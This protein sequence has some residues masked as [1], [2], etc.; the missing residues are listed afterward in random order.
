MNEIKECRCVECE[1]VKSNL[2]FTT[3]TG[4]YCSKCYRAPKADQDLL[5][6]IPPDFVFRYLKRECA[7]SILKTNPNLGYPEKSN[8]FTFIKDDAVAG[9]FVNGKDVPIHAMIF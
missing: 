6:S 8:R 5:D 2:W 9:I 1:T 3:E 4:T 7:P